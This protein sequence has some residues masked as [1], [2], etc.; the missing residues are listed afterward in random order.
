MTFWYRGNADFFLV[1]TKSSFPPNLSIKVLSYKKVK[2]Q[3]SLLANITYIIRKFA[4]NYMKDIQAGCDDFPSSFSVTEGYN[5][6]LKK[7]IS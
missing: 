1:A 2:I 4:K 7:S 5:N 3:S 6:P